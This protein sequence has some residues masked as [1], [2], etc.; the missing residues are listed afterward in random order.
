MK[1]ETFTE[2][3]VG[4][5]CE[6]VFNKVS[7]LIKYPIISHCRVVIKFSAIDGQNI[8]KKLA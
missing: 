1:K 8:E 3:L 2:E 7:N 4:I 5:G 6:L